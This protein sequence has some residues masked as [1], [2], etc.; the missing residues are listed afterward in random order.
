MTEKKFLYVMGLQ[1]F[2][3]QETGAC[4]LRYSL[5]NQKA[6]FISIS[7]E[8]LIRKKYPHTWPLHSIGYCMDHYGLNKMSEIDLIVSD[9]IREE[10]WFIQSPVW[11]IGEFDYL[12]HKFDY[13]PRKIIFIEHHTAHAASVYYSSEFQ[14][15]GIIIID[16][17]G[18]KHRTTTF[19]EAK[20]DEINYLD[21]YTPFG[22]GTIY[23]V[24]SRFILGFGYGGEGKTMGLAPFGEPYEKILDIKG[25]YDG[26]KTDFSDFIRRM[27]YSDILNQI[28]SDMWVKSPLKRNYKFC[29]DP[30]ELTK[31]YFARV[32]YDIQEET[33]KTL[34]HLGKELEK[35]INSKN[36]CISGGVALNSV[37]NK[38]MFD[39]TNFEKFFAFPA[40]GD[41]GIPFGLA[42]WGYHNK[43]D[44]GDLKKPRIEFKH[45]YTGIEYNKNY[46]IS[47]IEKY[48]IPFKKINLKE[49]AQLIAD[50]KIIAWVQGGSEYGPRALGHR[51]ILADSRKENLKDEI[52]FKVKHR[53]SF[54]PFAP[55][56]LIEH[57]KEYFDLN[58]ESPFMLLVADVKNPEK[59]PSVTHVDGTARVQTV[60]K[61]DNDKFYELISE[62]YDITGVPVILNTSFN[63]AGE[64]IVETPEDAMITF[65]GTELSYLVIGDYLF[66]KSD[67]DQEFLL[68]QM[69]IDRDQK[70]KKK[71]E[72]YLEKFYIKFD[73]SE[74]EKYC[75]EHNKMAEWHSKYRAKYELE[76]QVSEWKLTKKRIL[77][78]GTRDHTAILP[79]Y[80]N[81][82]M[83]VNVVGFV[84]I[85][86][87]DKNEDSST[88]YKNLEKSDITNLEYDLILISSFEY[89]YE[90]SN[91]IESEN[92]GKSVYEI[93]DSVS[94]SILETLSILP[95]YRTK[96][97]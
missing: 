59:I 86:K 42:I 97:D 61:E 55:A 70:I 39:A 93:Y 9:V 54:R 4:I 3:G 21:S 47:M 10:R 32:A 35:R 49:V 72:E 6:D 94:R 31:P 12:K 28:N 87:L 16:G 66:E 79:K 77:I 33:E 85:G 96:I 91:M 2:S 71:R 95:P 50:G 48:N 75:V 29:K 19:F 17:N 13:D 68:N 18:S 52:N 45:A 36:I 20:N 41:A 64:P 83:N 82:F 89:M 24:V 73:N 40:A 8:R 80:I 34:I 26:I 22:I 27:P 15:S 23:N 5:E 56:V 7:E 69:T 46:I 81:D 58:V 1:S 53:E 90:I 63:D 51:S 84:D 74:M 92:Y 38:K 60:T 67:V 30:D 57:Y 76:K 37:A 43:L 44:V 25:K 11:R 78:I 62:F 14:D 65:L 88:P